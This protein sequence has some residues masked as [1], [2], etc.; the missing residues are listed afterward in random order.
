MIPTVPEFTFDEFIKKVNKINVHGAIY[1]EYN[2]YE[3]MATISNSYVSKWNK[4]KDAKKDEK[5]ILQKTPFAF[6]VS[7]VSWWKDYIGDVTNFGLASVQAAERMEDFIDDVLE[8]FDPNMPYL[9]CK[10]FYKLV[11]QG[12]SIECDRYSGTTTGSFYRFIQ[13]EAFYSLMCKLNIITA[14]TQVKRRKK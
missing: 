2:F 9:K 11:E 8:A 10:Q 5:K 1:N 7:E 4:C 13:L 6:F 12:E 3:Y 14:S